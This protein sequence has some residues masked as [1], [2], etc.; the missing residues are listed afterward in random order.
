MGV[1]VKTLQRRAKEWNIAT[2]SDATDQRLKEIIQEVLSQFPG[3]GEVM[4]TGHLNTKGIH[5]QRARIGSCLYSIR[6]RTRINPPISRR[7]YDV[8]GPNSMWHADGNHKLIRYRFVVH[9]AIDGFSRLITYLHCA[10]KY[11][12]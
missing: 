3:V 10:D 12:A 4:L 8:P 9:C 11:K 5:V 2:H 7:V 6:G 1:S